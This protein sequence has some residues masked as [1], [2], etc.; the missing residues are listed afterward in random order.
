MLS[1]AT[2][3]KAL[4]DRVD[5][6]SIQLEYD[7][8]RTH[9][10]FGKNHE[11]G[12]RI[13]I[14][15]PGKHGAACSYTSLHLHYPIKQSSVADASPEISAHF[16]TGQAKVA[17]QGLELKVY[18]AF[19]LYMMCKAAKPEKDKFKPFSVHVAKSN[20]E[21]LIT[22]NNLRA[23]KAVFISDVFDLSFW[24]PDAWTR[25]LEWNTGTG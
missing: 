13:R 3:V 2:L 12:V 1:V 18:D 20:I 16:K 14:C 9:P 25:F 17:Q 5:T 4:K 8:I 19:A 24:T 6:V 22:Q 23:L 21:A 10:K 15:A 7:E 11:Y